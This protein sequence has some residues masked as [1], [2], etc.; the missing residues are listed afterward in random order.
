MG[1]K[2]RRYWTQL[3]FPCKDPFEMHS[4]RSFEKPL[5]D[6]ALVV[7]HKWQLRLLLAFSSFTVLLSSHFDLCSYLSKKVTTPSLSDAQTNTERIV[8]CFNRFLKMR[9]QIFKGIIKA[10]YRNH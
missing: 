7:L 3:S 1:D 2:G 9:L 6:W 5:E 8:Q 4:T 10:I